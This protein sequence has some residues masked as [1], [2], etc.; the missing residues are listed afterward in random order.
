MTARSAC[1]GV[2]VALALLLPVFGSNW[3]ASLIVAV[4]VRASGLTTRGLDRQGL[5]RA[6]GHRADGPRRRWRCRSVPWLGVG[7]HEGQ[8]RR[9]QVGHL[10]RRWR[11]SGPLLVR[12][13]VKVIV[14]PTLGVGSL[15]DLGQRPG[16]PAAASRSALSRV[17]AGVRVELVGVAD[18]GRVGLRRAGLTTR[19]RD[20]Q[21]LRRRRRVTVPTAQTPVALS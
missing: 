11:S 16:R 12:V 8:A 20:G 1:C 4:L 3:S 2:S 19:G 18:R 7:R 6:G 10:R 21:R 15:T 9:Q 17:V 14:S 13:T 5:R